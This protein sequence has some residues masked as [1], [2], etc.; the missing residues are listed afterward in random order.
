MRSNQAQV[1]IQTDPL[2]QKMKSR[3]K[4]INAFSAVA[5]IFVV[6]M[7]DR[8][9]PEGDHV[10]YLVLS[11]YPTLRFRHSG[12]EEGSWQRSHP[13]IDL[14]WWL[15]RRYTILIELTDS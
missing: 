4:I 8:V 11:P 3:P 10:S 2:P 12:G 15:A 7:I 5:L 13:G 9:D 6:A 14:P 1:E